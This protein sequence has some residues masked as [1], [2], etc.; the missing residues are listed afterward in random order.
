MSAVSR[1]TR[2]VAVVLVAFVGLVAVAGAAM[3]VVSSVAAAFLAW[4]ALIPE[5]VIAARLAV[6]ATSPRPRGGSF[7]QEGQ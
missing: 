1:E 6:V 7:N 3:F 2:D 4:P 5:G